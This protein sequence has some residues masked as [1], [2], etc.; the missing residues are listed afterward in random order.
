MQV[1]D[2]TGLQLERSRALETQAGLNNKIKRKSI[3]APNHPD[4][5]GGKYTLVYNLTTRKAEVGTALP[6]FKSFRA[7]PGFFTTFTGGG[8]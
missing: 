1:T 8:A 5:V 4:I 2:M 3:S 7:L 6:K